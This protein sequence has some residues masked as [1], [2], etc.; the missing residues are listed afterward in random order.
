MRNQPISLDL[1]T[2][3]A[4]ILS[5]VLFLYA[6][7]WMDPSLVQKSVVAIILMLAGVTFSLLLGFLKPGKVKTTVSQGA[8]TNI[9]LWVVICLG[10]V[11]VMNWSTTWRVQASMVLGSVAF[12]VLI[13]VCEEI[14]FRGFITNWLIT[15]VGPVWGLLAGAGVFAIYHFQVY[16]QD[17]NSVLITFGAGL[18]LGWAMYTTRSLTAPVVAHM[19]VNFVGLGGFLMGGPVASMVVMA[20][21]SVLLLFLLKPKRGGST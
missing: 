15:L 7:T 20:V 9:L 14:F 6:A 12:A 18:M 19:I 1:I 5:T 2:I 3:N 8:S 13:G 11:Y 10:A 4:A 17:L 16:G 21:L